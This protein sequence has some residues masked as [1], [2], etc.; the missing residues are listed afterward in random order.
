MAAMTPKQARAFFAGYGE[1]DVSSLD[2]LKKAH[3]R[4]AFR[5]HPDRRPESE[6][7][8]A[9]RDMTELNAAYAALVERGA[10]I[11][12]DRAAAAGRSFDYERWRREAF[13]ATEQ[14]IDDAVRAA[15]NWMPP[16]GE[17]VVTRADLRAWARQVV[18]RG[19]VVA[20]LRQ[21][22]TRDPRS[23]LYKGAAWGLG[24]DG[25]DGSVVQTKTHRGLT[26]AELVQGVQDMIAQTAP[27]WLGGGPREDVSP[28]QTSLF[29]GIVPARRR[30]PVDLIVTLTLTDRHAAV[31][32]VAPQSWDA[33][34]FGYRTRWHSVS[35]ERPA[36]KKKRVPKA[37]QMSRAKV[38]ALFRAAG[39]VC[40]NPRAWKANDW[41]FPGQRRA[42]TLKA[43]LMRGGPR[44]RLLYYGQ[45]RAADVQALIEWARGG[46]ANR[47]CGCGSGRGRANCGCSFVSQ[48]GAE[49]AGR[50]NARPFQHP[51]DI[52]ARK[53][54]AVG[55]ILASNGSGTHETWA[56]MDAW[57]AADGLRAVLEQLRRIYRTNGSE[58]TTGEQTWWISQLADEQTEPAGSANRRR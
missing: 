45:I 55:V 49:Y 34:L 20:K 26:V 9:T 7:S 1:L 38:E 36:P 53:G 19:F 16:E 37:E 50:A 2:D 47:A 21:Y 14:N 46:R 11:L 41:G 23:N 29:P 4:L 24:D 28:R 52:P 31:R 8:E 27:E 12:G 43:K 54:R 30:R 25:Y 56:I 13:S 33:H 39:M 17:T 42:L 51:A 6:R 10:E 57:V 35:F 15:K 58:L 44:D 48:L 32:W 5:L 40:R 22:Q 18:G 3:R